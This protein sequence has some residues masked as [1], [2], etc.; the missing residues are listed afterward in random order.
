MNGSQRQPDKEEMREMLKA[1]LA[2]LTLYFGAIRATPLVRYIGTCGQVFLPWRVT[3]RFSGDSYL[4][5]LSDCIYALC[6]ALFDAVVLVD[7]FWI[8]ILPTLYSVEA[9]AGVACG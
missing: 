2:I 3:Q 1:N 4:D 9:R 7:G 6:T 8:C 5:G